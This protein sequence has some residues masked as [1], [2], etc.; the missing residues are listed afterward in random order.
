[1]I[2]D[3][4]TYRLSGVVAAALWVSAMALAGAFAVD[5]LR[6]ALTPRGLTAE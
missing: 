5:L 4:A 3:Q 1:V 6:R 2:V